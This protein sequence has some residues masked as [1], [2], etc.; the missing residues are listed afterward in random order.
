MPYDAGAGMGSG[1]MAIPLCPQAIEDVAP[2]G[3]RVSLAFLDP[4]SAA[5]FRVMAF[6]ANGDTLY[7]RSYPFQ[8]VSI[9]AEVKDSARATRARGSQSQRDAAAKCQFRIRIRLFRESWSVATRRLARSVQ[10]ER[11]AFLARA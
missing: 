6:R 11:H 2:D 8:S 10:R 9:P 5:A 3:S 4:G 7:S 1:N